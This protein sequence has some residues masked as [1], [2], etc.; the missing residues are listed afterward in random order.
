MSI[1]VLSEKNPDNKVNYLI[2]KTIKELSEKSNIRS[3]FYVLEKNQIKNCG[4][5]FGCWVK[6]PGE[7]I[8]ND[9]GNEIT[10]NCFQSDIAIIVTPIHFGS[11]S[12]TIKLAID[13]FIPLI[14]P[15]FQKI[16]G[17]IHH[18]SRYEKMPVFIFIGIQNKINVNE[19]EIFIKLANRNAINLFQ[20]QHKIITF[21]PTNSENEIT[22]LTQSAINELLAG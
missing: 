15:F 3:S 20:K 16:N 12:S 19:K 8:I 10:K 6:T 5:C 18:K 22:N 9:L 11:Y 21:D 17:E 7:C 4:G 2:Q 14:S 1:F 13:R